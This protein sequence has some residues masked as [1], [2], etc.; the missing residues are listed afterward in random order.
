M[1]VSLHVESGD[2]KDSCEVCRKSLGTC[3]VSMKSLDAS[4]IAVE[5]L[6]RV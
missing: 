2:Q 5:A 6:G 4:R 3:I 1:T